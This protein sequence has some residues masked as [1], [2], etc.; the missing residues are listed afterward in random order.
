MNDADQRLIKVGIVVEEE[1]ESLWAEL[2]EPNLARLDNAPFFAYGISADD[3]VEVREDS[4]FPGF[5]WFER[6]REK[7]GS[8][9]IRVFS[10]SP[11]IVESR[12][13][14]NLDELQAMG[15]S[16]EGMQPYLLSVTIPPE[17]K[18]DDVITFLNERSLMWEYA[19]PKY[20]DLFPED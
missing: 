7:G 16:Y 4:K 20:E 17:V 3:L 11:S 15:C 1:T 12:F 8:R 6:I 10:K 19:D 14:P 18:L 9:T 13:K 5:Y 2:I